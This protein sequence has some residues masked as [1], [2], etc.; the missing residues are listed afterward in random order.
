MPEIP[1]PIMIAS[2]A[3]LRSAASPEALGRVSDVADMERLPVRPVSDADSCESIP[4]VALLL[5]ARPVPRW[6]LSRLLKK[7]EKTLDTVAPSRDT[8]GHP[9]TGALESPARALGQIGGATVQ[10]TTS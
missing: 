10:R 1:A 6:S 8:P 3:P 7:S 5:R 4:E 9:D 2:Y